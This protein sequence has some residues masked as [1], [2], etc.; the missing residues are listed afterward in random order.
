MTTLTTTTLR[1]RLA[2]TAAV[3]VSAV[4]VLGACSGGTDWQEPYVEGDNA[5]A[6]AS[7]SQGPESTGSSEPAEPTEPDGSPEN[8]FELTDPL[9]LPGGTQI[10]IQRVG[11]DIPGDQIDHWMCDKDITYDAALKI[12]ISKAPGTTNQVATEGNVSL[13]NTANPS[14]GAYRCTQFDEEATDAERGMDGYQLEGDRK[15]VGTIYYEDTSQFDTIKIRT[16]DDR[17]LGNEVNEHYTD[18]TGLGLD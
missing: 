3:A 1:T 18:L 16:W 8:P 9:V 15:L 6:A 10:S 12:T 13:Y 5:A 17:N 7:S 2:A 11:T 4:L 14:T